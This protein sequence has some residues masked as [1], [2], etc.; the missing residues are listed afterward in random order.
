MAES[1]FINLD[2]IINK[3]VESNII[4][5]MENSE[6]ENYMKSKGFD[7]SVYLLKNNLIQSI[8][9]L[10]FNLFLRN[11]KD[12]LKINIVDTLVYFENNYI[13]I[14]KILYL[15]DNET[16]CSLRKELTNKYNKKVVKN[17]L[18]SLFI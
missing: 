10:K 7:I 4:N 8:D 15:I 3:N 17:K 18:F 6:I 1:I 14:E 12:D 11:I 2:H 9:I 13:S 16:K 5:D